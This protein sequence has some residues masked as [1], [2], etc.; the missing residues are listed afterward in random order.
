MA[1]KR[2]R[3]SREFKIEAVRMV[4]ESGYPMSAAARDLGIR[5]ELLRRWK[6]QLTEDPVHAFPGNGKLKPEDAE[7]RQLKRE[8]QRLRQEREILKKALAIFSE[9][10][11]R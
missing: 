4:T 3:F 6:N 7:L 9:W 5:R 8:N 11:Q 1:K 10:E 2:R